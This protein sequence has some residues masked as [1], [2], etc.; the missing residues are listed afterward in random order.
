MGGVQQ[1]FDVIVVG[2]GPAGLS[3]ALMLGRCRRR[4]LVCDAGEPRNA[5]AHAV[6]GFFTR[7]GTAPAELL[8]LGREQLEPY[9]VEVRNVEVTGACPVN[10]RFE[11]TLSDGSTLTTK[12]L[13]LA[14]G[15]TDDIPR[16][17]GIDELYGW[18]VHH[19]PYCDGWEARDQP[20]ASY[21]RGSKGVGLALSLKTW[22]DDV[23]LCTDG[24]ARLRLSERE[25]LSDQ[26]IPVF[27]HPIVRLE[28]TGKMLERIVFDT[29]EA[30]ARRAM[31]FNTIHGHR[32]QLPLML[33]C[34]LTK[35]GAVRTGHFEETHIPG[36]YVA[37][38]AS[39]DVQLV[40]IA[41][42][43]GAKAAVA[44]NRALQEEE[45]TR[46]SRCSAT[47]SRDTTRPPVT[48]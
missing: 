14:T 47:E 37:G 20:L 28:G 11:L 4:V 29:G 33:G 39:E 45:R 36:L 10:G 42:A 31:F 34:R 15:V 26:D 16:I 27:D 43:E 41:A 3:A 24:P 13:L 1:L 5:A 44:I 48:S 23:I 25:Q 12:K 35:A 21:G 7:D 19:C 8:K 6:H 30:V 2:G 17:E 38:D 40:V 9:G 46:G 22:S 18:S 32:S